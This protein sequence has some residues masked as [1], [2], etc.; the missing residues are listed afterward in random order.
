ME[1][2]G[3]Q[4]TGVPED[5]RRKMMCDNAVSFFHLDR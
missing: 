1:V 5:E 3:A 4:L 2:M